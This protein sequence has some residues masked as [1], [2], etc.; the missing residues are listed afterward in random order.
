[1]IAPDAPEFSEEESAP[2]TSRKVFYLDEEENRVPR[3][4]R[5]GGAR[6]MGGRWVWESDLE[7]GEEHRART[8]LRADYNRVDKV[9]L[10][11]RL[12]YRNTERL[13]PRFAVEN[14]YTF[15]R[16]RWLYRFD[17]EQP[18]F[19][20]RSL[21]LGGSIF[22]ETRSFDFD[23]EV[24]GDIENSL[25]SFFLRQDFRDYY[26][27]DGVSFFVRGRLGRL[28]LTG[29]ISNEDHRALRKRTNWSL[30]RRADDFPENPRSRILPDDP[31]LAEDALDSSAGNLRSFT[32]NA[33][34]DS[35]PRAA[36]RWGAEEARHGNT[37]FHRATLET[38]GY[39]LGGDFDFTTA[40]LDSRSYWKLSPGQFLK[41]RAILGGRLNG[42]LP[43]QKRYYVGGIGT[44]H[45]YRFKEFSGDQVFLSNL[46]YAVDVWRTTQVLAF[47]EAGKAWDGGRNVFHQ[48][49]ES[50][51]GVGV[52]SR[53]GGA[54]L[55]LAKK[56]KDA[57]DPLTVT[58]RIQRT[59]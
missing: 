33:T 2:D 19:T 36:R 43:L 54:R 26:E 17:I 34:Y 16:R 12:A 21:S 46:E 41:L 20:R 50:D 28:S 9:S 52:Q 30:F 39:D 42:I 56:V 57:D 37:H 5:R 4:I 27:G 38:G 11:L 25:S 3:G 32:S 1:V 8:D 10:A 31:G 49:I 7:G 29:T 35:R 15:G 59:F 53:D 45:A 18:L 44:L 23:D 55:L 14:G 6:R 40:R 22:R 47:A 58:F 48:E 13:F 24:V 51:V